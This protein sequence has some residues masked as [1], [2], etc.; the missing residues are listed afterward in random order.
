M[1]STPAN[2]F[3][4]RRA[5]CAVVAT[6]FLGLDAAAQQSPAPAS[7]QSPSTY[8]LILLGCLCLFLAWC[9]GTLRWKSILDA[10]GLHFNYGFLLQT[11]VAADFFSRLL[12]FL[13]PMPPLGA[14]YRFAQTARTSREVSRSAVVIAV[15]KACGLVSF[16]ALFAVLFPLA[17]YHLEM[18][19][20]RFRFVLAASACLVTCSVLAA[21]LFRPRILW[22]M[23]SLFVS[24]RKPRPR[25]ERI[26]TAFS[27][28]EGKTRNLVKIVLLG[29]ALHALTLVYSGILVY[30]VATTHIGGLTSLMT[31][32][33]GVFGPF[34]DWFIAQARPEAFSEHMAAIRHR[35]TVDAAR[36]VGLVIL[37]GVSMTFFA[38]QLH[39]L[40]FRKPEPVEVRH[41][42]G[43]VQD[44]R[45]TLEAARDFRRY[46]A[47]LSV[48]ALGGGL[49]AGAIVGLSEAL[50]ITHLLYISDELRLL[51]WGPLVYGLLISPFG[52]TVVWPALFFVLA[53][54]RKPQAVSMGFLAMAWTLS[55]CIIVFGRFRYTRDVLGEGVMSIGEAAAIIGV[56]LALGLLVSFAGMLTFVR[57]SFARKRGALAVC[58]CYGV[59]VVSGATLN[60][61]WSKE[62]LGNPPAPG[63]D[64]PNAIFIAADTLRADFLPMYSKAAQA[65]TPGLDDFRKDAI[66]FENF[67]AQAPW[68]KP[69]FGSMLTGLYPTEHEL[70]GKAST[71]SPAV[72]TLTERLLAGGYY[73]QGFPNNPNITSA[74]GFERGFVAYEYLAPKIPFLATPSVYHL[75]LHEVLRRVRTRMAKVFPALV[76]EPYY[77]PAPAVNAVVKE[78][79]EFSAP[80]ESP[81]FLFFHYMDTHDPYLS[82]KSPPSGYKEADLGSHPDAG[83]Y[84]DVLR[85]AYNYELERVDRSFGEII[86]FFKSIGIYEDSLIIFISDHGEEFFDHGGWWHAKTHYDEILHV[87]MLIKLPGNKRA[88]ETNRHYGRQSDIAPTIR[89]RG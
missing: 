7:A 37:S 1:R 88:G 48:A 67:F 24:P 16:A 18:D 42:D 45:L 13:L 53:F 6:L 49:V 84:L 32:V 87:P 51:W 74:F 73:T 30:A 62:H 23:T 60:A 79:L 22:L 26:L 80:A 3:I 43:L 21:S 5:L 31:S 25:L 36:M 11:W 44:H 81:F 52:L 41:L 82:D 63:L 12:P 8:A 71:L 57:T 33:L 69:T 86:A 29:V 75:E 27:V 50:W 15:E 61:I 46:F 65:K 89:S 83:E 72:E 58:F 76:V 55:A 2:F 54:D 19:L 28:F 14:A 9:V 40:L 64:A 68:T 59:L 39:R 77:Q 34:S 38:V 47:G 35:S 20:A 56:A 78:W 4:S 70:I 10:S 66:L 85:A 17:L